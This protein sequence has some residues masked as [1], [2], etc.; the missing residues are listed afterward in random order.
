MDLSQFI[1]NPGFQYLAE[2]IL[3]KLDPNSLAVCRLIS[4]EWKNF[5]DT[6]KSLILLQ[7]WQVMSAR[8]SKL[9]ELKIQEKEVCYKDT[10][11]FFKIFKT[12]NFADIKKILLFATKCWAKPIAVPKN[13]IELVMKW[14]MLQYACFHNH[15]DIVEILLRNS[16]SSEI[17]FNCTDKGKWTPLHYAC[18]EGCEEI[19]HLLLTNKKKHSININALDKHGR[20][21]FSIACYMGHLSI[22]QVFLSF[23]TNE[24]FDFEVNLAGEQFITPLHQACIHGHTDIVKLLLDQNVLNNVQDI[25]GRTPLY[26]ACKKGHIDI[27]KTFIEY[28]SNNAEGFILDIPANNEGT[29]LHIAC[30]AGFADIVEVLLE[31]LYLRG[32]LNI[33]IQVFNNSTY[34]HIACF[35]R[36][37]AVVKTLLKFSLDKQININLDIVNNP[38]WKAF[39]YSCSIGDVEIVK[40]F[41]DYF[42]KTKTSFK[43]N[44]K[45]ANSQSALLLACNKGHDKIVKLILDYSIQH[46]VAIDTND[47]C[48]QGWTPIYSAC[49]KGFSKI[50]KSL[51][52]YFI[53]KDLN[54]PLT[55]D[56]LKIAFDNA[57]FDIVEL[58]LEYSVKIKHDIDIWHFACSKGH[59][60][61]VRLLLKLKKDT[62]LNT[63]VENGKNALQIAF[64]N[65][66]FH[67]VDL[68]LEYSVKTKHGIYINGLW[69]FAC[70]KGHT[71]IVRLLL[72][73]KKDTILN[74]VIEN[75][76]TALQI[77]CEMNYCEIVEIILDYSNKN[78][79][80]IGINEQVEK[81]MTLFQL[82]CSKGWSEVVKTMINYYNLTRPLNILTQN[83]DGKT[84]MHLACENGQTNV[85]EFF[86]TETDDVI[87]NSTDNEGST[88]L[89]LACIN[90]HEAIVDLLLNYSI[91]NNSIN[92]HAKNAAGLTPFDV[93]FKANNIKVMEKIL[94]HSLSN[95]LQAKGNVCEFQ[96]LLHHACIQGYSGI[97]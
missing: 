26:M 78:D 51:L 32:D 34:L 3:C 60:K 66:H 11:K 37:S 75:G 58:L 80:G 24:E 35:W 53:D 17:D 8:N 50:V 2:I 89:H 74:T 71:K 14:T 30:V 94:N 1:S 77:V 86:L 81:N 69:Q 88:L 12:L 9:Y 93:A 49:N 41:L 6:K 56:A 64:D 21:P 82:S 44:S 36:Q 73:L 16:K 33:N 65:G 52:D 95:D 67:I 63:F 42:L 92:I 68:L 48:S 55:T 7:I 96:T 61:I 18:Q 15:K 23:P 72:E 46:D 40:I 29:P 83:E 25:C 59:D 76:K 70:L 45:I 5:I 85:V 43:V 4:K 27:V 38:G 84:A 54:L 91:K 47:P 87:Y 57:H 97:V 31:Q 10:E 79:T 13:P 20:T 39:H 19:V 22:V 62:I 90:G 28:S